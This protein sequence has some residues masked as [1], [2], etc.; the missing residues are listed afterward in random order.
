M[1]EQSDIPDWL[2]ALRPVEEVPG[3]EAPAFVEGQAPPAF[4]EEEAPSPFADLRQKAGAQASY[5]QEEPADEGE[6]STS[7]LEAL[8]SGATGTFSALRQKASSTRTEY[9][10]TQA[11]DGSHIMTMVRGL[12][13][14]QR[15]VVSLFL[16][17]D[18]SVIGCLILLVLGRIAP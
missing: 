13:P 4:E 16:F 6:A 9:R 5:E 15:F 3:E 18:V 11:T 8:P 2:Q 7:E 1:A 10:E 12:R 14:W 17:L